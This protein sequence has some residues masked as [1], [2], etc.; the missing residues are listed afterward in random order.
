MTKVI[1]LSNTAYEEMK[2]L[3]QAGESFS[4][5]VMRLSEKVRHRPLLD[6]FGR[7]EGDPQET[8]RIKKKLEQDRRKFKTR[9]VTLP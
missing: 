3:K 4:D 6:F 8:E 5:V 9:E 7:W 2:S 1:S